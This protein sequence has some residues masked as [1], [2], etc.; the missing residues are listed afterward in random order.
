[1]L[2]GGARLFGETGVKRPLRL[3]ETR[4][5]GAGLAYL[6]YERVRTA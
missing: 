5:I 6:V 2:G 4:T 3:V 1:V